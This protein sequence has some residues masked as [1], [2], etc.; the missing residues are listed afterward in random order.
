MSRDLEKDS[1]NGNNIYRVAS[2][3]C[4]GQVRPVITRELIGEDVV[5]D[6]GV[7]MDRGRLEGGYQ[8]VVELEHTVVKGRGYSMYSAT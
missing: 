8:V 4:R 6:G 2:N 3:E 1:S 5:D 7:D